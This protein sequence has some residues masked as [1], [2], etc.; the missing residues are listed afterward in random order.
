MA[1]A[2]RIRSTARDRLFGRDAGQQPAELLAAD[3]G[4]EIAGAHRDLD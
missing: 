3:P 4:K 2:A 1:T